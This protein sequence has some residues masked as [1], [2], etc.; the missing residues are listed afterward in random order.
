MASAEGGSVPSGVEYGE[1]CPL[2]SRL[3][4]LG[5][6]RELPSGVRGR[7]LAENGFWRILKATEHSFLYLWQNLGGTICISVPRSKFWEDL[8]P[9]SCPPP[10]DLRP[11]ARHIKRCKTSPRDT[12]D[13]TCQIYLRCCYAA[14]YPGVRTNL[15]RTS[16]TQT[17]VP[18]Q[19]ISLNACPPEETPHPWLITGSYV[20]FCT[21]VSL[22]Q[23]VVTHYMNTKRLFNCIVVYCKCRSCV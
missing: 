22:A 11:C 1:E 6:R 10:R 8:A 19:P 21:D 17:D 18:G 23:T 12:L 16:A 14:R 20:H 4:G 3:R 15:P 9:H 7:V 2:S 5:E 13:T